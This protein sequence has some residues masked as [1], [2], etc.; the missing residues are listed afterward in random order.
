M[1]ELPGPCV[2]RTCVP[3]SLAGLTSWLGFIAL[4]CI[5]VLSWK[6]EKQKMGLRTLTR[7]WRH[8]KQPLLRG[9]PTIS[10]FLCD[11]KGDTLREYEVSQGSPQVSK[12]PRWVLGRIGAWQKEIEEN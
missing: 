5:R 4:P 9:T 1:V 11:A 2:A 10:T 7:R 6:K 3:S 8:A 12:S